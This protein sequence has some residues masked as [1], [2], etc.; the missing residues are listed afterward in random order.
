[1]SALMSIQDRI[2]QNSVIENASRT[3]KLFSLIGLSITLGFTSGYRLLGDGFDY[4]DYVTFYNEL[5]S[6]I[7][8]TYTR[9]EPGFVYAAWF[10]KWVLGSS[11]QLFASTLMT[12]SIFLKFFLFRRYIKH[13]AFAITAYILII[14]PIHEYT[15]IR[16]S[17]SIAIVL[18]ALHLAFRKK[19]VL[20]IILSYLAFNFHYTSVIMVPFIL[21][22]YFHD[23][24]VIRKVIIASL[25]IFLIMLY[26]STDLLIVTVAQ[27]SSA[28]DSYLRSTT[29]AMNNDLVNTY[30]LAVIIPFAV[31]ISSIIL[32]FHRDNYRIIFIYMTATSLCITLSFLQFPVFSH[33]LREIFTVGLLYIA[34]DNNR[35][36]KDWVPAFFVSTYAIASAY[37]AIRDKLVFDY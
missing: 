26:L 27:Y 16:I 9:F 21:A 18:V 35:F 23:K 11:Y 28:A 10:F 5:G 1:M 4:W 22:A 25:P 32:G 33:R 15:Q 8:W 13:Y 37:L 30:S 3:A 34:F 20:P 7:N 12:I 6:P 19:L 2:P 24:S 14:Y 31:L 36:L 17:I 29:Y